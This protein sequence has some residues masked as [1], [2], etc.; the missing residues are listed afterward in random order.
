MTETYEFT[1]EEARS[2]WE[3]LDLYA[4]VLYDMGAE[5]E[6]ELVEDMIERVEK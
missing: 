3:A 1:D 2:L 6:M 5:E 4:D